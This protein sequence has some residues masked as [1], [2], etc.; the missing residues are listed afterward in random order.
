LG[1]L[2]ELEPN[3]LMLINK[4]AAALLRPR[5]REKSRKRQPGE[6]PKKDLAPGTVKSIAGLTLEA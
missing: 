3:N 6:H 5:I 1:V 2:K 4:E